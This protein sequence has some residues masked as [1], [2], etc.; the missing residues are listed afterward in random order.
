MALHS[1]GLLCSA[2][3]VVLAGCGAFSEKA[4]DALSSV[5]GLRSFY[6]ASD[7]MAPTIR[8][9]DLMLADVSAYASAHPQRDDIVVFMPPVPTSNPFIKRVI[10]IPGDKLAI[11]GGTIV[12]N[13]KPLRLSSPFMH[14]VYTV[15]VRDYRCLVDGAPLDP[16]TADIPNRNAWTAADRLPRGCYFVIGD[17]ALERSGYLDYVRN[18]QN[19]YLSLALPFDAG[20]GNELTVV[21]R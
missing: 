19:G 15:A 18:P 3:L 1:K 14:P 16:A 7:A 12:V 2:L 10:A 13:D 11:R 4:R 6:A 9:H 8:T 20:R 17:N 21:T 5:T